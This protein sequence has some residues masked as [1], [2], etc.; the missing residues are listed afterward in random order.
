MAI[1]TTDAAGK[2]GIGN[3]PSVYDI[4]ELIGHDSAPIIAT[5]AKTQAKATTHSWIIDD[6]GDITM[7]YHNEISGPAASLGNT[8]QE[9]MNAVQIF[10][11]TAALS[12]DQNASAVYGKDTEAAHQKKKAAKL[13][14]MKQ[15]GALL[16]ESFTK[17][18]KAVEIIM[19]S[20]AGAA[21]TVSDI[22][23]HPARAFYRPF[24]FVY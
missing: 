14:L 1:I 10:K 15:E 12:F 23:D 20:L 8:K 6:I 3:K 2:L 7:T 5:I 11:T 13:H 24:N 21:Q 9:T 17:F 16:L 19:H 4:V 18:R 22:N